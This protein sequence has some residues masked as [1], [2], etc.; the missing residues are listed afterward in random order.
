MTAGLEAGVGVALALS[1]GIFGCSS[2]SPVNDKTDAA[3]DAPSKDVS[4]GPMD[5]AT[6]CGAFRNATDALLSRCVG[7]SEAIWG[8]YFPPCSAL[9]AAVSAGRVTYQPSK[10]SACLVAFPSLS[11]S[12]LLI[13]PNACFG[14]LGG[15]VAN[16]GPCYADG[17]CRGDSYCSGVGPGK[18]SC[19]GKC[20][21]LLP[22][23]AACT[24]MDSCAAGY[25]CG[26]VPTSMTCVSDVHPLAD[27]G[28]SCAPVAPTK[29]SIFC[30]PGLSCNRQNFR[31]APT[32]KLGGACT[33]GDALCET[34]TYCDSKT[35]KC[36]SD[37][38]VGEVCG[39][40]PA[41]ELMRCLPRL[42]CK[43]PTPTSATGSCASLGG[44]GAACSADEQC[45]S[46][47]CNNGTGGGACS[48]PC[49]AE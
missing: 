26:G 25:L 12:D 5:I 13:G 31:C 46:E 9:E 44:K 20:A 4:T 19:V 17:D 37:P 28:D 42:Y 40:S 27:E 32:G 43:L 45:T 16:G 30:A 39:V 24:E 7:G 3:L 14:P 38:G 1:L 49:T 15:T 18:S 35:S 29:P 34:F 10:V 2:S 6:F 41:G 21:K 33:P 8:E 36:V 22:G 23:G 48:A 11:C 47:T